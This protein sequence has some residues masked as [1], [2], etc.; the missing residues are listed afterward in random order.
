MKESEFKRD[1]YRDKETET[2]IKRQRVGKMRDER[3]SE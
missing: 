3:E 2:D 1:R